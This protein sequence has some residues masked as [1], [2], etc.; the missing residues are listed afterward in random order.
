MPATPAS[1]LPS[2]SVQVPSFV[3]Q[4]VI[5]AKRFYLNLNPPDTQPLTI[6]CGGW[7][8][9]RPD[10]GIDRTSFPFLSIEMVAEGGGQLVLAG[11]RHTLEPGT[12]FTY[13]PG[14]SQKISTSPGHR[15]VKYFVDFAG[16]RGRRLLSESRLKP[17]TVAKLATLSESRQA[18]DTLIRLGNDPYRTT[19]RV[20]A[21]QLELLLLVMVR[22]LEPTTKSVRISL[23]T[24]ERCCAYLDRH[25]LELRSLSQAADACNVNDAHFCRLF[26]R[27]RGETPFRY[28]TRLQMQWAADRLSSSGRLVREVAD[29]LQIDPFQFS[30]AFKRIHGVSPT[31]YLS[32]RR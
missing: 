6:V 25:F 7:E 9:C 26:S 31:A 18:F 12:I 19:A 20:C 1:G 32:R 13:G 23:A 16:E 3:S 10:Y 8:E 21:L 2:R 27:F 11:H 17:G 30:R 22:S 15:L 29:E 5:S 14:V 4:Q 28:L 24:F